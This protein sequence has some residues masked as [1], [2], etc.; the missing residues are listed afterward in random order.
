MENLAKKFWEISQAAYTDGAS[1]TAD[2]FASDMRQS[3]SHYF[4]ETSEVV[5]FLGFHQVCDEIEITNIATKD[6]GHGYGKKLMKRLIKHAESQKIV[7][8]FLEVRAS[9]QEAR[10]FYEKF[11]F[12]VIGTRKNYYQHPQE[13]AIMMSLKVGN[14]NE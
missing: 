10:L 3:H 8:I 2:Q 5:A 9:N 11:G 6:K 13:D 12:Q 7:S 4:T 14:A 1:W